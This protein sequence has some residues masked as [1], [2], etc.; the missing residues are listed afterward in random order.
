MGGAVRNL[1]AA[2]RRAAPAGV[3]GAWLGV[4]ELREL[5]GELARR[6]LEKRALP[7]IKSARADI[8]L[9]AALVLEAAM[10]LSGVDALEVTQAGLREGV[11][12]A[13]HL[14]RD[15]SPV[16]PD[17]RA[18]AVRN[19]AVQHAV[20]LER[21]EHVE[22]LALSLPDSLAEA[23]VIRPAADERELLRGAS[24]LHQH[25]DGGDEQPGPEPDDGQVEGIEDQD[26]RRP[27]PRTR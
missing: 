24:V 20:D 22:D 25:R 5:I 10:E 8:I 15:A 12:F 13:H 16:L 4:A 17:V 23:A 11:F 1:A 2:A 21:A 27:R 14:L 19:L 18:A 26:D 3:Q 9:G 7:G 6:P